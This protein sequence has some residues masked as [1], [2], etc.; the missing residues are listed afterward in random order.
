VKEDSEK[1]TA[2]LEL[3][4]GKEINYDKGRG[5]LKCKRHAEIITNNIS[6]FI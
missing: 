2:R 5:H 1:L 6:I 4:L 3:S